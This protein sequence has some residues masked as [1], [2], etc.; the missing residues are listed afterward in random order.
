VVSPVSLFWRHD[1]TALDVREPLETKQHVKS[2]LVLH[3]HTALYGA[4]DKVR[5]WW[6]AASRCLGDSPLCCCCCWRLCS[7]LCAR[8]PESI[9]T[10]ARSYNWLE[11]WQRRPPFSSTSFRHQPS[12]ACCVSVPP[13]HHHASV[14]DA[15]SACS[16][17]IAMYAVL[18]RDPY[19]T[20]IEMGPHAYLA[21]A[22]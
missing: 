10:R 1:F 3:R 6:R 9:A 14:C 16:S 12:S 2:A 11:P 7:A 18:F 20:C 19:I 13:G 17:S 15:S 4:F 5:Q 21:T 8:R 22:G